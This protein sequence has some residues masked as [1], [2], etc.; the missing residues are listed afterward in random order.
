LNKTFLSSL[1]DRISSHVPTLLLEQAGLVAPAAQR[2]ISGAAGA[3]HGTSH[4][5]GVSTIGSMATALSP[6]S[7]S[8]AASLASP[9][10][11][12]PAKQAVSAP[13]AAGG[14]FSDQWLPSEVA[15][16]IRLGDLFLQFGA[17]FKMYSQYAIGHTHATELLTTLANDPKHG[18]FHKWLKEQQADTTCK[19][20]SIHSLLI[21]PI[22]RIPRYQLLMKELLKYTPEG[23]PDFGVSEPF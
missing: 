16:D 8:S 17:F 10:G 23:H 6:H 13:A 15:L 11:S 19:G 14:Q 12:S 21:Q 22:Q 20:H 1:E 4:I 7:H 5:A 3:G 18:V 9:T 2:A